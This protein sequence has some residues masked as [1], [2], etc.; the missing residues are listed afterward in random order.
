MLATSRPMRNCVYYH[1]CCGARK[2]YSH[3]HLHLWCLR[4]TSPP[5]YSLPGLGVVVRLLRCYPIYSY[6]CFMI[7]NVV[8]LSVITVPMYIFYCS[9][10]EYVKG[11][12]VQPEFNIYFLVTVFKRECPSRAGWDSWSEWCPTTPRGR[13]CPC[14]PSLYHRA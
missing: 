1:T 2:L 7:S 10:H 11:A 4:I 8:G 9:G 6:A 13:L 5:S 12:F 3:N 14:L